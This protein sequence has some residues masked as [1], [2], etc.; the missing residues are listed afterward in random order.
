MDGT[1]TIASGRRYSSLVATVAVAMVFGLLALPVAADSS[2]TRFATFNA[3][4]NRG[5]AGAAL[6]DMSTPD[7]EQAQNVAAIIQRVRPEVLL[8]NEFDYEPDGALVDAFQT[9]YLAVAQADDLEPI[10]Y[11]Y[12]FVAPSNTG[13]ASGFDLNN[14]GNIVA[15]A[16]EPGYGDDAFGF[17][18]FP[19]QYGMAVLSRYPIDDEAVRTFAGF[20]WADMPD[21]ALPDD[22]TTDAP[23]DWYSDD[24]L[25]VF[26]LSSKS[27]WDIPIDIDGRTVHFL[28]SHPTPPTFDGDEDRNGLRNHDE[29]RFWADYVSGGDTAT[30]IYDDADGS[31]GLDDGA[32][33][34]IAGDQN[35]DPFDGDSTDDA[36]LALLDHPAIDTN[37]TPTS[38]GGVEQSEL[39]SGANA[40]HRGDPAADT[41]DFQDIND[42]NS[43]PGNLRV[44]YVLPSAGLEIADAGVFWPLST[45]PDFAWVGVF[46]PQTS[47]F[48][49]SDHRLVWVDVV[50]GA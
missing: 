15:D 5:A 22:P 34:V 49:S 27:H 4:L 42:S 14:D 6:A 46:D 26:R 38:A 11:A 2:T 31:G 32:E 9:N 21:A 44:D 19:G 8:L 40:Q 3:S 23:G 29:I 24:E 20:R 25:S 28:V 7:D 35:A 30:Y 10:D 50:T 39:Q 13:V 1:P 43:A 45:E 37:I 33:F 48:P 16:G 18:A 12:T 47:S 17:G 36:I 41:A